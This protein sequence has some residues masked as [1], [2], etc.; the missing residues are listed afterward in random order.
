MIELIERQA[1]IYPQHLAKDRLLQASLT[2]T[3]YNRLRNQ[4][5]TRIAR[6]SAIPAKDIKAAVAFFIKYPQLGA[7]KARATLIDMA[8]AWMS[9]SSLSSIKK[10]LASIADLLYKKRREEEKLLEESLRKALAARKGLKYT[11][12]KA[13]CPNDIWAIDFVN[14]TFLGMSF[15]ICVVYDEYSQL[16]PAIMIATQ[17]DQHLAAAAFEEALT[18]SSAKPQYVRRDNG[19]PFL[20]EKYQEQLADTQDYPVP[21]HS[22]WYNG[23]LESCNLSLK[24][25]IKSIGMQMMATNPDLSKEVRNAPDLAL[26]TLHSIISGARRVLNEEIARLKHQM[27]P[28]RAYDDKQRAEAPS[29]HDAFV[30][31]SMDERSKR[32]KALQAKPP[33]NPKTLAVKAQTIINRTLSKMDTGAIYVL[34]E[35]LNQRFQVF[36]A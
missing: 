8:K 18:Q 19:K 14:I 11:H 31:K 1:L 2:P 10:M 4:I 29:R 16:Y 24:A 3:S 25:T 12:K 36:E 13:S 27:T 34:R 17:G 23:A 33:R 21:P 9:S 26:E 22:P 15:V 32:M 28:A 35:I 30:K 20:T 6:E 7:G 5:Y